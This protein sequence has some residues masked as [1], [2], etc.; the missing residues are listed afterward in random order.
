MGH[1]AR[2]FGPV[3]EALSTDI[4][5]F[6]AAMKFEPTWQQAQ[7]LG[8]V[9][10]G[11]LRIAIRS[12]QGP[13]KCLP[14]DTKLIVEYSEGMG[15]R[16]T[17]GEL[18]TNGQPFRIASMDPETEKIRLCEATAF[19]SGEKPCVRLVVD[20][21]QSLDLTTDHPVY[22]PHGWVHA[23][24][25]QVG[26]LVGMP[27]QLP[28]SEKGLEITDSEIR[29][30]TGLLCD[31]S[32]VTDDVSFT[33]MPNAFVDRFLE[34]VLSLGMTYRE[35]R[36]RSAAVTYRIKRAGTLTR[37]WGLFGCDSRTKRIPRE[38]F[39]LNERQLGVFFNTLFACD[40]YPSHDG[41]EIGLASEGFI[42]DIQALLLLGGVH[43]RYRYKLA[44]CQSGT[45]DAWVLRVSGTHNVC[46]LVQLMG[47]PL[48]R[49]EA[50]EATFETSVRM[51]GNTNTDIVPV[52]TQEQ[53][54]EMLAEV[55][56]VNQRGSWNPQGRTLTSIR[57]K[58]RGRKTSYWSRQKLEE[59][60]KEFDYK[61]VCSKWAMNDI[62]WVK[63]ESVKP[64]GTHPVYDLTVPET[65]NFVANNL[66]VHNTTSSVTVALF[67]TLRN[68]NAMTILT[69]PTMRQCNEVWL[70]E[71]RRLLAG[72]D[73]WLQRFIGITKTKIEV[74]GNPD[75]GVK[76]VTA[77]KTENSQG[78]HEKN[79][80]IICEE[81]SGID[82]KII[83]QFEGTASNPNCLF[84]QIG[85]PNHRDCAFFDCFHK[86]RKNWTCLHW[87]AEETPPSVWFD[88]I[89]NVQLAEK[90]G[91]ESDIYR[92]R[93]LGEF[94]HTDPQCVIS[95]E[96][97][98]KVIEKSLFS[99]AATRSRANGEFPRQF[100]LDFA[101]FGGDENVLYRRSGN[102][103]VEQLI[104]PHADP[105][106]LVKAA[107]GMQRRASWG[108]EKTVY[109]ADAG[110]IGQGIMHVFYDEH[111]R[112][113]E[114]HNGGSPCRGDIYENRI[115]EAWF[116]LAH[117][118]KNRECYLPDDPILFTQLTGRKYFTTKKGKL[119]IESKDEYMRR[120]ND[121]P[122]RADAMVMAMYD[123]IEATGH[124][125]RAEA[126]PA[127]KRVMAASVSGGGR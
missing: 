57:D 127:R 116:G 125:S 23:E 22:T 100:G 104:L 121:S 65:H 124:V 77:T 102:A 61:G 79:M 123:E 28:L 27:R 63:V 10:R 44:K 120:G 32:T 43:G 73:P 11:D 93:V 72:A 112:V 117:K 2:K 55:G 113:L 62:Y 18:A 106:E 110:G 84:V 89:R 7:F 48:G 107:F 85:N 68:V 83:E 122:D 25:L 98:E 54:S 24:K 51:D 50:T 91:R 69:A 4:F 19:P 15:I 101:R 36:S 81:A 66:I 67:R 41:F 42:E 95:S 105:S 9:Q 21:G 29:V 86:D 92:I 119:I 34:D 70:A 118:I 76:T 109:V 26:D 14:F 3:Y 13:G 33:H 108:D 99:F 94:P 60:C 38:F 16:T 8:A 82:R 52:R 12:G 115:T 75:W 49:E 90:Y 53:V 59:F 56:F 80:T 40:G 35:D 6:A 64:I 39:G 78:F 126:S 58:Y 47:L 45:F 1:F 87:N 71:A 88:P 20:A 111:K 5:K 74:N 30:V 103:I 46:R 17:I 97:L 96:D 114:F 31:G 37:K